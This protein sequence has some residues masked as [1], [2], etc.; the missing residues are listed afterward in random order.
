MSQLE[1]VL[2]H[3]HGAIVGLAVVFMD[4]N[5]DVKL[6]GQLRGGWREAPGDGLGGGGGGGGW[7]VRFV[8]V[9]VCVCVCRP[10]IT[11]SMPN[12]T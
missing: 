8:C 11:M 1:A 4:L 7:E 10:V 6:T 5:G 12:L 9:C 2:V 3:G